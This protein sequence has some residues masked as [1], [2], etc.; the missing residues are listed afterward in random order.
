MTSNIWQIIN[1]DDLYNF[2]VGESGRIVVLS[3]VLSNTDENIKRMIKKFIKRKANMYPNILFLYH[4]VKSKDIGRISILEKDKS[5]YPK[6]CHIYDKTQLLLEVT[7]IEDIDDLY[8]SFEEVGD[9]YKNFTI[10]TESKDK[11]ISNDD[12]VIDSDDN[13][14][15][16]NDNVDNNNINNNNINNNDINNN[17][18]NNDVNNNNNNNGNNKLQINSQN[19][20]KENNINP[21]TEKKKILE[22]INLF[23]SKA[24]EFNIDFL[25]DIQKR[26]KEEELSQKKEKH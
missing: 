9:H 18:N 17:I 20:N 2:L 14:S 12:T 19:R 13:N 24:E 5:K 22:K 11:T 8:E 15:V 26:K 7:S 6:M 1:Y 21:I 10:E 25:K 16:N 4:V 23:R 3:L